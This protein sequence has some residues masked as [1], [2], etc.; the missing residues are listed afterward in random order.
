LKEQPLTTTITITIT[1]TI[2]AAAAAAAAAGAAAVV[3]CSICPAEGWQGVRS[4]RLEQPQDALPI[5]KHCAETLRFELSSCL[6]RACLGKL[7]F[8]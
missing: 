5:V 4:A 3:V 8:P 1:V 7:P 6:S 2:S